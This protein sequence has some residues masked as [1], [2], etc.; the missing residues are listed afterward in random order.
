MALSPVLENFRPGLSLDPTDCPWVSEDGPDLASLKC[1]AF[2]R[3]TLETG[4]PL[5]GALTGWGK[6]TDNISAFPHSISFF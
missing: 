4:A 3:P 1:H 6:G 2:L 5:R